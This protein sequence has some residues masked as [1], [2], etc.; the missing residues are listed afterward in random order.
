M[1]RYYLKNGF[2]D[3]Q[4]ISADAELAPDGE[5][6]I[7]TITLEE[8]PLYKI[9]SVSVAQG[10]TNLD[11]K[12]LQRAV[13]SNPGEDYDATKV[14]KTVENITIEAGKAGFAFAKV[15][16]DIQRDAANQK[17]NIVY[18]ITEGPRAYIERIDIIGNTRTLD[19]VIRRELRLFEGDA[20][21]RV[22]VDRGRR[23]LTALDFFEKIDFREEP[24]SAADRVVLIVEVVEKSTG[25]FNVSA[26]YS[27]SEGIIGSIG[28][29]ERNLL[30]RGQTV[31]LNTHLSFKRQS[32]DFG[33]T[34]PYFLGMPMSAGVDVFATR[35]DESDTTSYISERIGFAL[36][37]GFRLDEN[38]SLNFKYSLA[39]RR[40]K[41]DS[42]FEPPFP[43]I[44]NCDPDTNENCDPDFDFD[45]L[46]SPAVYDSAGVSW[47]SAV[48][49]DL[50][51]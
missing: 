11:P 43:Q 24:G 8:G 51:L 28:L 39:R 6:F 1:R 16:P 27:S 3:F 12:N 23:R 31:R 19:E 20:Y 46:P 10:D 14:D 49:C 2:A 45:D 48:G 21:N 34:E 36:R 9:N 4:V 5:S 32:V 44:R 25:S 33:F 30:G 50:H 47:K 18:N 29:T 41:I 37:N 17:L 26:G 15:E 13:E 40:I 42:D 22:L 7:I 38:Q 35:S